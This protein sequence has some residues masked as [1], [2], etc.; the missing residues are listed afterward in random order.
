MATGWSR[1]TR[2]VFGRP[3]TRAVV[4]VA[5]PAVVLVLAMCCAGSAQAEIVHAGGHTYGVFL[6]PSG[7]AVSGVSTAKGQSQVPLEYAGGPVMLHSNVY[8]IFWGASGSFASTYENSIIQYVKDLQADAGKLT[9]DMSV[10]T[11]YCQNVA[12]NATSC[13][14]GGQFITDDFNFVTSVND[15]QAYPAAG[16]DGCQ[17]DT[18]GNPGLTDPQLQAEIQREI[19]LNDWETDPASAPVAQYIIFTP[20]N[21]DSCDGPGSC[22]FGRTGGF[23]GY[24]GEITGVDGTSN[25]A[26]YSDEPYEAG[27][28]S[29]NAP[30]GVSGNPDAD[31]TLDTLAHG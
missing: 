2:T 17:S 20:K 3:V 28:D 1:V 9:N 22:A 13:P 6:K 12:V 19:A 5:V 10:S 31:G 11:Q 24:H 15:A 21:V 25:V 18:D 27:C 4:G 23:C 8:L 7:V 29:G 30:G 16:G 26:V 14:T